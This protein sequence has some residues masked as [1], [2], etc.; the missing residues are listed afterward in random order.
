MNY[1]EICVALGF[2]WRCKMYASKHRSQIPVAYLAGTSETKRDKSAD[3][4]QSSGTIQGRSDPQADT[5]ARVGSNRRRRMLSIGTST[6]RYTPNATATHTIM[7][8]A[9]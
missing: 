5:S 1:A 8:T 7:P 4:R 9:T 2:T 3:R 6:K